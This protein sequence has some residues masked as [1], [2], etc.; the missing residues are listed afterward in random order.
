MAFAG[1]PRTLA[2]GDELDRELDETVPTT[3]AVFVVWPREGA[4]Y[5]A[6]TGVLRRRLKRLLRTPAQP[7]RLLSLRSIAQR[8]DYWPVSSY[9]ESTLVLWEVARQHA[10]DNHSDILKLRYPFYLR[11]TLG[12]DFPRTHVTTRLS[13]ATARHYGP[14]RTRAAADEF[15]HQFLDLFQLRRCHEDLAPAPEHPGCVYGEMNMCLRPCQLAV[16]REEYASEAQRVSD[17]LL[18]GGKTMLRVA[19]TQRDRLSADLD[20][21]AAARE[22]KRIARIQEVLKLREDLA[23]D[24]EQLH[25]VAITR[26]HEPHVVLL[27]FLLASAWQT[28]VGFSVALGDQSVSMDRRLKE[29][30]ATVHPTDALMPERQDH[31]AI[32]TRWYHSTWRDGEWIPISNLASAPYRR[33]IAA[34][35]RVTRS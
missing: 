35:S 14:F 29:V 6:R 30:I 34:I 5:I 24:L 3:A 33:I 11:L 18:T 13:G 26:S 28:P 22:H 23:E 25:G 2:V 27:W 7:S 4:P 15:E 31:L 8:V 17:F 21:E 1:E 19:E 20:F 9:L 10:P 32:L 12:S 16:G